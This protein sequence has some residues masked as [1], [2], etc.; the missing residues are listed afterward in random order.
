MSLE[1]S[2]YVDPGVYVAERV[3]PGAVSLVTTP[4]VVCLIGPGSRSKRI[5]DELEIRGLITGEALSVS[6]SAPHTATLSQRS[7]RLSAQATLFKDGQELPRDAFSF[8]AATHTGPAITTVD[9]TAP[10]NKLVVSFDGRPFVTIAITS[11]AVDSTTIAGSLITQQL[12]SISSISAVTPA[13]I[14][15]GINKALA[16][17][18]SLGYGPGYGAVASV[19]SG[20][21]VRLTSP[22]STS[23]SDVRSLEAF[24]AA[25]DRG[26]IVFGSL[27]VNASSVITISTLYYSALSTYTFNYVSITS[28]TDTLA[29][30]PTQLVRLGAFPGVTS[31]TEATD[32]TR[33]GATIDWSPDTAATFTSLVAAATY[34]V[35]VNDTILL[36]VDG[37]AAISIDLNGLSSP[38]PGYAN[39]GTPAAATGAELVANI[40]AVLANSSVYGPEY[41]NVASFA[42]SRFTLTSP[43][44]GV[45]SSV[46]LAAPTTLSAVTAMF[47][48]TASQLPFTQSGTGSRPAPGT[49][50]YATYDYPR[51]ASDY[52]VTKRYFSPDSMYD[53][54]GTP[55]ASNPLAVAG[56]IAFENGAPSVAVVQVND[57]TFPSS[58]TQSEYLAALNA[59]GQTS[60]PTEIVPLTT[61]LATQVDLV[62]HLT[63][64][65]S[66][67]EQNYR[68]G[69]FGMARNTAIGDRDTPDT[70][71]YRAV[72][73]LQVPADSPARGRMILVAPSNVSKSITLADGTVQTLL[74]DGSYLAVAV[75]ARMTAFA[76]PAE[77][78]L[79]KTVTGLRIEDFQ[80]F[81]RAERATLASNG[82][83]V[84]TLDAG[85]LV[86]LDPVTTE[87]GGGRLPS[88]VEI[89]ASTQKDA[90]SSAITEIVD[91][92][93][94]GVV[95]A[96]LSEFLTQVKTYV[97][98]AITALISSGA[99]APFRDASGVTREIDLTKDIQAFQDRTDPTKYFFRYT[100][101]LR[102]PAKRFFGEYSVDRP[103]F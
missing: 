43:R 38:P 83:T 91:A 8:N 36:S 20:N 103:F 49:A 28:N 11:G 21:Q 61:S 102:Y 70:F 71:V 34:D 99:I 97:A 68:R 9:F 66:P 87:A 45:G 101:F 69:F 44:E 40:N 88:F 13:Q 42:S 100:Y 33:S 80:T 78:L 3:V 74:L 41:R 22:V 72:R 79:R 54:L 10:S 64:Q 82:V 51:P 89:S 62:A 57:A 76:S 25:Q 47:G 7:N 18:T 81:V 60:V 50:Y 96:N 84:V 95:P 4:T 26:A 75:A 86:L 63:N 23:V 56:T 32:F 2:G 46:Q 19:V 5:N 17:A 14:A 52:N 39:P 55:A 12:A 85:A 59:A 37:R 98:T 6:G 53:D 67:I 92:N 73:T 27:P 58:P 1:I 15:E 65:N 24:P 93:L 35:S 16:G 90:V 77:T 94:V 48:L 31:F 30:V 29:N